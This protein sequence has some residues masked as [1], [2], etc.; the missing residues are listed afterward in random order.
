MYK[1]KLNR[2]LSVAMIICMLVTMTPIDVFAQNTDSYT[3]NSD[4]KGYDQLTDIRNY[5]AS[6]S[7]NK[8]ISA[9]M[10]GVARFALGYPADERAIPKEGSS[11][12]NIES[13]IY[14]LKYYSFESKYGEDSEG[15]IQK[16]WFASSGINTQTWLSQIILDIISVGGDP[17]NYG[18]R[19][20]VYELMKYQSKSIKGLFSNSNRHAGS[21]DGLASLAL[22]AY[23]GNEWALIDDAQGLGRE[24]SAQAMIDNYKYAYSPAD[25]GKLDISTFRQGKEWSLGTVG[26]QMTQEAIYYNVFWLSQG[27]SSFAYESATTG[28]AITGT[29]ISQSN[30]SSEIDGISVQEKLENIAENM[31]NKK[32]GAIGFD[33]IRKAQCELQAAY[34][35]SSLSAG[36]EVDE[37]EWAELAKFQLDDGSYKRKQG[38]LISNAEATA[39]AAIA[40]DYGNRISNGENRTSCSAFNRLRYSGN[41]DT[42]RNDIAYVLEEQKELRAGIENENDFN[43]LLNAVRQACNNTEY[44]S[45]IS[46][47]S[48]TPQGILAYDDI[49]MPAE[50]EPDIYVN[51][52]LVVEHGSTMDTIESKGFVLKSEDKTFPFDRNEQLLKDYYTGLGDT[53]LKSSAE[54][55]AVL[56]ILGEE[57]LNQIP[58]NVPFYPVQKE[59]RN[60][61]D[62][63]YYSTSGNYYYPEAI[64]I[65]DEIALGNN[66]KKFLRA[67]QGTGEIKEVDLVNELLA[68]QFEDGSLGDHYLLLDISGILALETFFNGSDWGNQEDGTQKGRIGA[69]ESLLSY[70]TDCEGIENGRSYGK[71]L[72]G[73][74]GTGVLDSWVLQQSEVA[75]LLS[76]WLDDETIINVKGTED[77]LKVLAQREIDGVIKTLNAVFDGQFTAGKCGFKKTDAYAKYISA[78][79]ASGNKQIVDDKNVWDILRN[80]RLSNGTYPE[81]LHDIDNTLT[82]TNKISADRRYTSYVATAIGDYANNRSLLSGLSFDISSIG[83][84][85]AVNNDLSGISIPDTVTGN[86]SLISKGFYGS[87]ISWTSS[88]EDIINPNTGFVTRPSIGQANSIVK[89]T[90]TALRNSYIQTREFYILVLAMGSEAQE[91]VNADYAD[92]KIPPYVTG[93]ISLPLKG[94]NGSDIRWHSSDEAII[95]NEGAVTLGSTEK[96]VVLTASLLSGTYSRTK[97]FNITVSKIIDNDN[98]VEKAINQFRETYNTKRNLTGIY[99][100]VFAAKSVLGDDFDKYDFKVYDVS[101]HRKGSAWQGTDYA[102]IILQILS[103]GDNPYNYQGVNYVEQLLNWI[104]KNGWGAWGNPS[105]TLMA[106]DASAADYES[107]SFSSR[108]VLGSYLAEL[109][110]LEYGPDLAGWALI[111]LSSHINDD[112]AF[113]DER[114]LPALEEFKLTLKSSQ[115]ESGENKG[116]FNTGGVEGGI[117]TLSNG[118]VVSGFQALTAAGLSGF[119]LT[120]DYWKIDDIGVLEAMYNIDIAGKQNIS[121]QEIVEF[122]DVYYGDSVWKRV[123]IKKSDFTSLIDSVKYLVENKESDYTAAS[124]NDLRIAY[125]SALTVNNDSDKMSKN[126]YGPSYFALRDAVDNLK[127]AG[128]VSV[129]VLGDKNKETII[130]FVD[131]SKTGTVLDIIEEVAKQNRISLTVQ[132]NKIKEIAGLLAREGQDW[133]CYK[134]TPSGMLRITNPL[135]NHEVEEG[136]ELV[137]KYCSD[138]NALSQDAALEE[139]LVHDAREA[140]IIKG[141]IDSDNIVTGNLILE[142]SGLFGTTISWISNKVFAIDENGNVN[143][144]DKEDVKVNLTAKIYLDGT[145]AEKSFDV[146]VKSKSGGSTSPVNKHAY[147]RVV[148]PVGTGIVFFSKQAIEV[149]AGET[150]FSLLEKTGL[151][152]DVDMNTQYGV[153]IRGIEGLSEMDEG[154]DSGWLYRVNGVFPGHSAALHRVYAND[155]VEWLYTRD[156]GKDVGGYMPGVE[157]GTNTSESDTPATISSKAIISDGVAS[158]LINN[159]DVSKAIQY[160]EQNNIGSINIVPIIEGEADKISVQ[161]DKSSISQIA[162]KSLRLNIITPIA[163]IAVPNKALDDIKKKEGSVITITT[164]KNSDNTI[165][166]EIIAGN[167]VLT[168]IAGGI[169]LTISGNG[170]NNSTVLTK[171]NSDGTVEIIKKSFIDGKNIY[172]FANGSVTVKV[173][174]NNKIFEDTNRSAWYNEAVSFVSSHEL[175][176]GT[177]DKLFSPNMPMS[178]AMLVTVLHRLEGIPDIQND[179]I[180][181]TDVSME[182]YYGDAVDWA[183]SEQIVKGTGNSF[184]PN[185]EIS[186]EELITILYRYVEY[187]DKKSNVKNNDIN[188][189]DKESISEWAGE[190]MN[191]AIK[192]GIINGKE[193]NLID[194]KGKATRAEVATILERFIKNTFR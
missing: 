45:N 91:I 132:D 163:A 136:A 84:E 162:D 70:M 65:I 50:G 131:V 58:S 41:T 114:I 188:F 154:P 144:E 80:S 124:Y 81:F 99:W 182:S 109:K 57:A 86:L 120:D 143:R 118:C 89:L 128:A 25:G 147:I 101:S 104:A 13:E 34:I 92:L 179:G 161:I 149:E 150:V 121:N 192:N 185:N 194:P 68:R 98:V 148:G 105:W 165:S 2:I 122:G 42:V 181:F 55:V 44:K 184:N 76:R 23:W 180:K 18:G 48:K 113:R 66:P 21:A 11:L 157:G 158:L 27:L 35:I 115:E 6:L 146:I 171:I 87:D 59:D 119:D 67:S 77:E 123:G 61:K 22:N 137:F 178:R 10:E 155:Y 72:K 60:E 75:I 20:Y 73:N 74:S 103:Q 173:I 19:N 183:S 93:D 110:N 170:F 94:I 47:F 90:A 100:D 102:A 169:V 24:A 156:L 176:A 135:N 172:G 5:Y 88:N 159:D 52:I 31:R 7:P 134:K 3:V 62:Y 138:I 49:I 187:I 40:L 112:E 9:P 190:A 193:N 29:A 125:N 83:D 127:P 164:T 145:H 16:E 160:V 168:D 166:A 4:F 38:D 30:S 64:A 96:K 153:Y 177:S 14:K 117:L 95:T 43:T 53:G 106:L 152:L 139:H 133:Y 26:S 36:I 8:R 1:N 69:I 142:N 97:E 140:L 126:Y 78:L 82:Q 107:Y 32:I 85:E 63:S 175:F 167:K 71:F 56:S 191:W 15:T 186:R 12:Q 108:G 37:A 116:L 39:M 129:K 130:E 151:S 79:I 54:P 28:S 46:F 17:S 111:P 141:A 189:R 174:D 51:L 33:T